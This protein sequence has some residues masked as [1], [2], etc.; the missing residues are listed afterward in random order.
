MS[1]LVPFAK[2]EILT[3]LHGAEFEGLY[4]QDSWIV[5]VDSFRVLSYSSNFARVYYV[6]DLG[7]VLEFSRT[8]GGWE[9][10]S[11]NTVWSRGGGNADGFI[12]PYF[13]HSTGGIQFMMAFVFVALIMI[14]LYVFVTRIAERVMRRVK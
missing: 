5:Y 8:S 7:S 12:W 2:H 6:G 14:L 3:W 10:T 4:S 1:F 13:Y 9:M 11:S